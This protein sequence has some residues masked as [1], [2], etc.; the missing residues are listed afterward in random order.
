MKT[1]RNI[2]PVCNTRKTLFGSIRFLLI[3]VLLLLLTLPALAVADRTLVVLGDSLSAGYGIAEE[4][5]WV[6]RL[7]QRLSDDFSQWRVINASTSGDT[8]DGGLR[9]IDRVI[10]DHNPD[11]MLI[12]LGGNDGLRG[13]NIGDIRSNLNRMI[14]K[15]QDAGARVLLL[16]I[17]L[18]PNYGSRYTRAFRAMYGDLA[19]EHDIEL[20]PFLLEGVYDREGMMQSDRIHPTADAQPLI[21]E[22]VWEVLAPMLEN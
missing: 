2:N 17:E 22:N 12:Q 15:S 4:D 5:G 19:D 7:E 1:A 6:Y 8:T 20:L 21:L 14:E 11:L 18:P 16:G 10:D 3:T 13:F 9:R